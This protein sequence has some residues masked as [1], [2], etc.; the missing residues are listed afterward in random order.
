MSRDDLGSHGL[1]RPGII[2]LVEMSTERLKDHAP[3]AS[4]SALPAGLVLAFAPIHKR[5]FGVACGITAAVLVVCLT[6]IHLIRS[7]ESA[8]PL[9]LLSHTSRATP[10]R[11]SEA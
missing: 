3:D 8:Y 1:A 5:H 7:P 11:S 2:P 4:G 10:C 9:S 6:L